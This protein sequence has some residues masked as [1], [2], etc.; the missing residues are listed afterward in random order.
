MSG[1]G[2]TRWGFHRLTDRCARQLVADADIRPADL[3]LDIGAGVGALTAPLVA[4]GARVI[5]VELHPDRAR[6]LRRRFGDRVVVV[7]T[8]ASDLRLPRRPFRVVANPPFA[9]STAVVRRLTAPG[10]RLLSAD[11]VMPA[12]AV[13][14]WVDGRGPGAARWSRT[15]QASLVRR[16]PPRAFRPPPP[17][18]VAV[19]RIQRRSGA[20][21]PNAPP[22]AVDVAA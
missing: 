8:D 10:S 15:W 6:A 18:A 7:Q 17:V 5:A 3:V 4:A 9:S 22:R 21:G 1:N 20:A 2:P 13:A 11:L 14:R 16:L 12:H 19:L